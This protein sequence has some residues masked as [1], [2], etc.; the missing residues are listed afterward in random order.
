MQEDLGVSIDKL[1][2]V[3][4]LIPLYNSEKYI[5]QCLDSVISQTYKNIELI[6]IDDGS[7]DGSFFI[8]NKYVKKYS[9]IKVY[10]QKNSGAQVARNRAFELSTGG[11]IQYLDA[12]DC[13]DSNKILVQ[14]QE[15]MKEE[16]TT[17]CFGKCEYF[18]INKQNILSRNLKIYNKKYF[19]PCDFLYMMWLN[20]E[21][22]PPLS[23]LVHRSLINTSGGWDVTLKKNQDGEFFA[24]VIL[25]SQKILFS[26]KSIS[27]YRMDTPSSISKSVSYE[28][29]L[30]IKKSITLYVQHSKVC[31]QD[32]SEA[33]RTIYTRGLMEL[34]PLNPDLAQE[35]EIEKDRYGISG[36]R[37]P[38]YVRI[39]NILFLV[40]GI[41]LTSQ[42][43]SKLR[44]LRSKFLG[45][46]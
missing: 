43:Q 12:D 17:L 18:Q 27:Y 42:L 9:Y 46:I 5:S 32:F 26:S 23:F 19:R 16:K 41:K 8:V 14:V 30:S 33:L 2:L 7:T 31:K 38:R 28:S 15:L 4:V 45:K 34:Y 29:L 44:S 40:L 24:R 35:V 1:P 13:L 20:A 36:Y 39:Y 22:L 25:S 6:I 10:T 21:A 3:S 37:Y 11:Y